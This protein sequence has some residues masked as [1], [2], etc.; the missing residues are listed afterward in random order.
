MAPNI[1]HA[2]SERKL[3]K[4]YRGSRLPKAGDAFLMLHGT[5][6]KQL[7]EKNW[8]SMNISFNKRD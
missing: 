8:F 3:E 1:F 5:S 2:R 4:K 6:T 7:P